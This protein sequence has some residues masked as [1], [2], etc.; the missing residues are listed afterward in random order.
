MYHPCL[1]T[2]SLSAFFPITLQHAQNSH[3]K[4]E[5]LFLSFVFLPAALPLV[6]II[7]PDHFFHHTFHICSLWRERKGREK[8]FPPPVPTRTRAWGTGCGQGPAWIPPGV[9]R[10]VPPSSPGGP[11]GSVAVGVSCL[12]GL[13][14]PETP[15]AHVTSMDT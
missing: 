2:L 5:V 15:M 9:K 1:L 7:A 3:L 14:G 10:G 4:T 11:P 12:H 13:K 6:S 8:T